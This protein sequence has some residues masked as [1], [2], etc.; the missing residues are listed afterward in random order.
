MLWVII[1]C[2]GKSDDY[3]YTPFLKIGM[4]VL[5]F[6]KLIHFVSVFEGIGFFITML[7]RC[8]EDLYPFLFSYLLFCCFFAVLYATMKV[9][10]DGELAHAHSLG[11]FG[12]LF[13]VVWRNSVGKLGFARYETLYSK[14]GQTSGGRLAIGI[15]W[16]IYATQII[17]Q[18]VVMLNFMIAIIDQTYKQV[19]D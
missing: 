2:M 17:F 6:I 12:T 18:L 8:T 3:D 10:I 15:I 19:T 11:P 16:L 13:L 9:E 4:I 5:S 1:V 14:A 7:Q